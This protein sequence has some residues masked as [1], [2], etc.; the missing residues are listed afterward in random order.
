M[1][2]P[3]PEDP[4]SSPSQPLK[5]LK[6]PKLQGTEHPGRGSQAWLPARHGHF[7]HRGTLPTTDTQGGDVSRGSLPTLHLGRLYVNK[8]VYQELQRP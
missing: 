8:P 1:A 4:R 6:P 5:P 3:S 2:L 7:R